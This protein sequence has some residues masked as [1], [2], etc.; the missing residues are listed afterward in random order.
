MGRSIE[1]AFATGKPHTSALLRYAVPRETADRTVFDERYWSAVHTPVFD[2]KGAV[3]FVSQNAIDVTDLYRFDPTAGQ[4]V[5]R[6]E[7]NNVPDIGHRPGR[8][9]H[10][11]M[12]RILD[13][14]RHQLQIL[15]NQAPGFIAVLMGRNFVFE[16][17]N[18]AYYQL[19]GHRPLIGKPVWEALPE[20]AGQGS[21][22]Y[23]SRYLKAESRSFCTIKNCRC[24]PIHMARLPNVISNWC[25]SQ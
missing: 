2:R 4:Y 9:L 1:L 12:T 14:E 6:H 22:N 10:E 11:A 17:V 13:A 24:N 15:F 20:V 3:A 19:V 8:Q 16:M 5:L 18:E 23:W 21:R 25:I 7:L